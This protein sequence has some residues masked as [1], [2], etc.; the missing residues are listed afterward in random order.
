MD[1]LIFFIVLGIIGLG[2]L[3]WAVFF[4]RP[5]EKKNMDSQ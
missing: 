1:T 5:T 4:D 2:V 3:V